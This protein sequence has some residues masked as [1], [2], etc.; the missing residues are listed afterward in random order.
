MGQMGQMQ[1]MDGLNLNISFGIFWNT[2]VHLVHIPPQ[3]RLQLIFN[4]KLKIK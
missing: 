4:T 3:G 1:E 2:L